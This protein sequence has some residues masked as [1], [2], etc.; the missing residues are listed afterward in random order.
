MSELLTK[1]GIDCHPT[2]DSPQG[3][4]LKIYKEKYVRVIN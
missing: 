2:G 1:L 4:K 3:E